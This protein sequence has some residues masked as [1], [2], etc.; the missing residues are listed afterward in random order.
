VDRGPPGCPGPGPDRRRPG[1]LPEL[2]SAGEPPGRISHAQD[3]TARLLGLGFP[4]EPDECRRLPSPSNS[5]PTPSGCRSC[6]ETALGIE[7]AK[8]DPAD[9]VRAALD[10]VEAGAVEVL[11]DEPSRMV[12]AALSGDLRTLYPSVV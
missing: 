9:V 8:L 11:V 6:E 7:V 4:A 10:G 5:S 12:K 3:R 1:P 2:P